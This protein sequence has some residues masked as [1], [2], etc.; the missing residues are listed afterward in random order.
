MDPIQFREFLWSRV[1]W[2]YPQ[3]SD[4]WF[5]VPYHIFNLFEGFCWICF[6]CLVLHRYLRFRHSVIEIAYA[7]AFFS[8]GLT[9]FR[10][11][12]VLESWLVLVKLAN[13]VALVALRSIVMRR[14]YPDRKMF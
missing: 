9:D 6:S 2:K 12:Y 14:Y 1:W 5:S 10:E 8:F 4:P 3:P 13:L 7:L 11:A